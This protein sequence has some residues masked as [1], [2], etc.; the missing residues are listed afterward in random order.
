MSEQP[1]WQGLLPFGRR[2]RGS[3]GRGLT[4]TCVLVG[5]RLALPLPLTAIVERSTAPAAGPAAVP[6]A[7]AGLGW[8]DP[9]S[10][11]AAAFVAL[12]LVAGLAEHFQRLAFAH[13]AGRSVN[14]ARSAALTRIGRVEQNAPDDLVPV[15]ADSARVKQGLK[16]VLNH[17]ILN[18]LLVL[19]ACVA[20]AVTD[21]ALGLVQLTGAVA[22]VA[23]AVLGA[24]R[25][26]AASAEHRRGEALI[27]GAVHG[28][29]AE[30]GGAPG[31]DDM[32]KLH[33][34]DAA[35]GLADTNMTRWEGRTTLKVHV[36]LA[37]TAAVVLALGV[38]AAQ[39]GRLGTGDLFSVMAY[40][41]LLQGPAVR[42]AR[43]ITRIGPVLVSAN[44]MGEVLV[45]DIPADT[46]R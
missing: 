36:V 32:E 15:M 17:I 25:V 33:R 6:T 13:F 30:G 12:A 39:D 43:Q 7:G 42:F 34:L 46:S 3:F 20:L 24:G 23:V 22:V 27:A 16:G 4:F 35:S 1:Q 28:L 8:T 41:L 38:R 11:L 21:V 26:A 18:G 10:L 5:S 44:H 2:H 40:L 31:L 19:G 45:G 29:V 14:D 37:V 9:V